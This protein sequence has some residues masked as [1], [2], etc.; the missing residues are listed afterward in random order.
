[1]HDVVG[2]LHCL[3]QRII[4]Q[5][6]GFSQIDLVEQ[7]L[8]VSID[9]RLQLLHVTFVSHCASHLISSIQEVFMADTG[10]KETGDAC[11]CND[12]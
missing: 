5:H 2:S 10:A 9:Q 6:V 12:W 3:G 11:N 1:M 4:I 7:L 8:S